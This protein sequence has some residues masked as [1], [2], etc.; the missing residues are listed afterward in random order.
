MTF[1]LESK[2]YSSVQSVCLDIRVSVSV[3]ASRDVPIESHTI[4][5]V[6]R[7]DRDSCNPLGAGS[8]TSLLVSTAYLSG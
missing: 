1:G 3:A 2:A 7:L 4:A 6:V 5:R 8:Q